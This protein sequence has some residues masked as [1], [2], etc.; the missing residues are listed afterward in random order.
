MKK[1]KKIQYFKKQFKYLVCSS[2]ITQLRI[3]RSFWGFYTKNC[4]FSWVF[5]KVFADFFDWEVI[6]MTA[7]LKNCLSN[8]CTTGKSLNPGSFWYPWRTPWHTWWRGCR[9]FRLRRAFRMFFFFCHES[10]YVMKSSVF[11]VF[12]S[13]KLKSEN[14]CF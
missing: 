2:K 8:T 3:I 6:F 1:L 7:Y 10:W 5:K 13:P 12:K 11:T 14:L 9:C 4:Q